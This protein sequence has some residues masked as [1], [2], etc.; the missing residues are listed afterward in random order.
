MRQDSY[1]LVAN[2]PCDTPTQRKKET[3]TKAV[4]MPTRTRTHSHTKKKSKAHA[5]ACWPF[6][7]FP[8]LVLLVVLLAFV[9]GRVRFPRNKGGGNTSTVEL[10]LFVFLSSH[11]SPFLPFSLSLS[12]LV[13]NTILYHPRPC[14]CCG[15]GRWLSVWAHRRRPPL[16][17]LFF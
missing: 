8:F 17:L 2:G 6:N 9:S 12:L 3:K 15:C 5:R 10:R 13:L 11:C 4:K 16:S 7:R 1:P 14:C